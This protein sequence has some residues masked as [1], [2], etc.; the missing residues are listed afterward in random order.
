MA[1]LTPKQEQFCQEYLIDLNATQAAIRAGY[2]EDSAGVEGCRLLKNANVYAR[3]K[4]LQADRLEKL[5]INQDWVLLRLM[6]ISDRCMQQEEVKE[7]DYVSKELKGTGEYQFDSNGANKSTELIGK[8]L[9]MFK[10]RIEHTGA[11]GGAIDLNVALQ[12]AKE[13]NKALEDGI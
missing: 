3:V 1:K 2:S 13:I 10:D 9:G 4:E 5:Q 8:H 6:Q 11:N 12:N 7:F